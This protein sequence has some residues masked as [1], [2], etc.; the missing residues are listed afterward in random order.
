MHIIVDADRVVPDWHILRII[1]H[2]ARAVLDLLSFTLDG[3]YEA[4][5][6]WGS[7][8]SVLTQPWLWVSYPA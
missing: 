8:R 6:R 2:N 5:G 7:A 4:V 1:Q 3:L